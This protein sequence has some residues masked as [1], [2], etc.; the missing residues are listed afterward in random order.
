MLQRDVSV[1]L[2]KRGESILLQKRSKTAKR[3]PNTWGLFGGGIEPGELP[4]A[5]LERELLEEL[6]LPLVRPKRIWGHPY[7]LPE[8][9]ETGTVH[10]FLEIYGGSPLALHEGQDMK[11]ASPVE[12]LALE[13]HPIYR[14]I[15]EEIVSG[16]I[17]VVL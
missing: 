6:E 9:D 5:A 1:L 10:V 16:R 15:F 11:W 13:L 7:V 3:F 8:M 12:A 4:V 2:L 17:S 14:R